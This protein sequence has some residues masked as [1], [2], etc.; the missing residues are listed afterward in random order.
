MQGW[1][2]PASPPLRPA[3]PHTGLVGL[4]RAA[5]PEHISRVLQV[6]SQYYWPLLLLHVRLVPV[7]VAAELCPAADIPG[8]PQSGPRKAAEPDTQAGRVPPPQQQPGVQLL[9][10]RPGSWV[11]VPTARPAA[12]QRGRP[13]EVWAAGR[14]TW[15]T[16]GLYTLR[17]RLQHTSSQ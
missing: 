9:G 17:Y 3:Q 13:L 16:P 2:R 6:C 11:P 10:A 5:T 15:D 14:L 12:A 7:W 4:Y 8:W 1:A